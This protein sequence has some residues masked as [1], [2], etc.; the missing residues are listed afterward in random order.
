MNKI[1]GICKQF[2]LE[3]GWEKDNEDGEAC[4]FD[5]YSKNDSI[6]IDISNEEI[7]FLNDSGD[8]LHLP[9]N[10]FALVGALIECRQI[11]FNFVSVRH[12]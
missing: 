6:S 12:F 2:L 5:S 10:Y 9:L 11:G 1:L 8:F 3:N 4:E 7:V